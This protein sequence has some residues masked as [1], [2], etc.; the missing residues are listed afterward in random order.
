MRKLRKEMTTTM[1]KFSKIIAL[2][3][4]VVMIVGVFVTNTS[5][6]TKSTLQ[7]SGIDG[8]TAVSKNSFHS[9]GKSTSTTAYDAGSKFPQ[10]SQ[11]Y[12]VGTLFGNNY[13]NYYVSDTPIKGHTVGINDSFVSW[14]LRDTA[15]GFLESDF[16]VLDFDVTADKYIT[17]Y[18]LFF[19]DDYELLEADSWGF[20]K[21]KDS[22]EYYDRDTST[23][24]IQKVYYSLEEKLVC[25]TIASDA[26]DD[27]VPYAK[28]ANGSSTEYYL[29]DGEKVP[30]SE[31][32]ARSPLYISAQKRLLSAQAQTRDSL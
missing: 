4:L 14:R 26:A 28:Y 16:R 29:E 20:A 31:I 15:N 17:S 19:G 23:E 5:A 12:K 2:L 7:L 18:K 27:F 9:D 24:G 11:K 3:L 10:S 21:Y 6:M 13:T 22:G 8:V 30:Y 25:E 1:K 32:I